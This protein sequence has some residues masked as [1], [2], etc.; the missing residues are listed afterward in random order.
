MKH[1]LAPVSLK[2]EAFAE[3]TKVLSLKLGILV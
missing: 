3:V 1:I 2:L